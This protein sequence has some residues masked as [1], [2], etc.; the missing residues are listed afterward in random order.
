MDFFAIATQGFYPTPTP[1][2]AEKT[3]FTA[4]WGYL[5]NA[6]TVVGWAG[7]IKGVT[8]PAKILGIV[9]ASIAKVNGIS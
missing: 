7:K 8:N 6:T 5:S 9:V 3:S 2:S 1:T 4:S